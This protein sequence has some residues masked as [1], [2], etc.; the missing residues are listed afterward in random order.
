MSQNTKSSKPD[1]ITV[2]LE[3]V[4][5]GIKGEKISIEQIVDHLKYRGYG[6]ILAILALFV[7]IFGF[8]PLLPALFGLI[9]IF[10]SIQMLIGNEHP[11]L[12][13]KLKNLKISKD[14]LTYC[15]K[16]ARPYT[17][18]LE[19]MLHMRYIFLFNRVSEIITAITCLTLAC[20]MIIVGFI[21]M[22]PAAFSVPIFL[23]GIGYTVQ[24]GLL[25]VLGFLI[26]FAFVWFG[27]FY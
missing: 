25:I 19:R 24:D 26:I 27:F 15:I 14:K 1:S 9:I 23:F 13:N 22:L 4:I 5:S 6:P 12:P 17:K 2:I 7:I 20:A 21:P 3:G 10:I 18:K 11:W 8:I 16:F